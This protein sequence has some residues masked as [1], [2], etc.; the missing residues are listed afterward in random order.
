M[1]EFETVKITNQ[2]AEGLRGKEL[3]GL[4]MENGK[5]KG[6]KKRETKPNSL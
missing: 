3:L 5:L 6:E 2:P 4:K 1:R